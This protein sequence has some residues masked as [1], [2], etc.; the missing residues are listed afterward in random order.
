MAGRDTDR[1]RYRYVSPDKLMRILAPVKDRP[2]VR[3]RKT[4]SKLTVAT[5]GVS[6]QVELREPPSTLDGWKPL[7][8]GVR[9]VEELLEARGT[10]GSLDSG[11][12]YVRGTLDAFYDIVTENV[13]APML[14]LAGV[15][16]RT[17]IAVGGHAANSTMGAGVAEVTGGP[18]VL[19]EPDLLEAML[20]TER[21][22]EWTG[23]DPR[24]EYAWQAYQ[25]LSERPTHR[26]RFELLIETEVEPLDL[27]PSVK[28]ASKAVMGSPVFVAL[29]S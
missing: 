20:G 14:V 21:A 6:G 18:S 26:A 7:V 22:L 4:I 3:L 27:P 15:E 24:A 19:L 17:L 23:F 13:N 8:A 12:R 11:A 1:R 10:L 25:H 2:T 16:G 28:T 5:S 9:R 29:D